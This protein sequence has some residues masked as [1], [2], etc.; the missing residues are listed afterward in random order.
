ML[1][2][3]QVDN[4]AIGCVDINAIKDLVRVV[5]P[6]DSI[7]LRDEGVVLDSFNGVIV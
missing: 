6:K 2:C 3:R 1:I 5:C 7:D 4:L